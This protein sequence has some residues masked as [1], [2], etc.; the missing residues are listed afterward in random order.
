MH[1]FTAPLSLALIGLLAVGCTL[2]NERGAANH[3]ALRHAENTGAIFSGDTLEPYALAFRAY[4]WG[5]PLVEWAKVRIFK[6]RPETP[7]S[8]R[9]AHNGGAAINRFGA[10]RELYGPDSTDGVGP[11]ND[12]L[13]SIA[14]F[15]TSDGPFVIETPDFGKR[16]YTFTVYMAD[17]VSHQS[18]GQRTHGGQL[19]PMFLYG[20]D[21]HGEVPKDMLALAADTRYVMIAGRF[22]VDG[23]TDDLARVHALQDRIRVRTFAAYSAGLDE[24][25][26]VS[27]Q[28]IPG[29]GQYE[30][31]PALHFMAQLGDLL[32]DWHLR[33]SETA[34]VASLTPIGLSVDRGFDASAL[35][36]AELEPIRR[37]LADAS[38]LVAERSHQLGVQVKGWTINYSGADFGGDYLLRA[39]V[40]KDQTGVSIAEEAIYP[41]GREDSD[42]NPLDGQYQYRIVIPKAELPP[43]DAFWSITLYDD[44]GIMVHNPINRYSI[45]DRTPGLAVA[46]DGSI[47]IALQH[48]RPEDPLLNW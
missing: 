3:S 21:Y 41:S 27:E 44:R 36:A 22:L 18:P 13:Y 23:S 35:S 16:Y 45:G 43:V 47:T 6:T 9:L 24:A 46:D 11:N 39:A 29:R 17:T 19:P 5:M 1:K 20:P 32:R 15:D 38:A 7:F 48:Q 14:S 26:P 12:T 2:A 30:D 8:A 25:P 34:L 40:A 33:D 10:A 31:D 37:G 4:V 42:G 28:H